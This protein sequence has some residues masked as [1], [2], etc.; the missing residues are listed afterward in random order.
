MKILSPQPRVILLVLIFALSHLLTSCNDSSSEETPLS[1]FT[2][3][4]RNY[5]IPV[6]Y[7]QYYLE[8]NGIHQ[9]AIYLALEDPRNFGNKNWNYVSL[10]VRSKDADL[11]VNDGTYTWG[12]EWEDGVLSWVAVGMAYS[13]TNGSGNLYTNAESGTLVVSNNKKKYE[14]NATFTDG[15]VLTG[16]YYGSLTPY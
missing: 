5:P 8:E 7:L 1:N 10:V 11:S 15:K 16:T 2:Y 4:G 6:G 13:P 9:K 12:S 14:F 3:D